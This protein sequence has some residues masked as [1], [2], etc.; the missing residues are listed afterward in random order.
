MIGHFG[1]KSFQAIDCNDTDNQ[2]TKNQNTA[3]TQRREEKQK[4]NC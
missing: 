2:I 3:Y 4:K 1:D